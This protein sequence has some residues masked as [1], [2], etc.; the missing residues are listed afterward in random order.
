MASHEAIMNMLQRNADYNDHSG[1]TMGSG[2]IKRCPR[3]TRRKCV[4]GG[5]YVGGCGECEGQC[6]HCGAGLVGGAY[7]GGFKGE[8]LLRKKYLAKYPNDKAKRDKLFKAYL[9]RHPELGEQYKTELEHR[10]T[11]AH[12][13]KGMK[14]STKVEKNKQYDDIELQAILNE[15]NRYKGIKNKCDKEPK[16]L[17]NYCVWRSDYIHNWKLNHGGNSPSK[18]NVSAGWA[19]HKKFLNK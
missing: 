13:R 2:Y 12:A 16:Q 7:V 18:D 6:M 3:G 1:S 4:K 14:K 15:L 8:Q 10:V 9:K 19:K 11:A 17:Q 5:A